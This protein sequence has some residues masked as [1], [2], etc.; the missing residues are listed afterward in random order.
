[1]CPEPGYPKA[2][3]Y[4]LTT[5]YGTSGYESTVWVTLAHDGASP[6]F[7]LHSVNDGFDLG[8]LVFR[9]LFP[10]SCPSF[11]A[12]PRKVVAVPPYQQSRT[13]CAT[14]PY[15]SVSHW[16]R[17]MIPS[18]LY[19]CVRVHDGRRRAASRLAKEL[20]LERE[21]RRMIFQGSKQGVN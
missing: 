16:F 17:Q 3:Y 15:K 11:H 13:C 19:A 7:W 10:G 4:A 1:M 18:M 14:Q 5:G 20:R 8:C 9:L 21:R 12:S 2:A 6:V